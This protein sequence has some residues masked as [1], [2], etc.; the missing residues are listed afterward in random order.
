MLTDLQ[1]HDV[2]SKDYANSF[3]LFAFVW[4]APGSAALPD[5]QNL[6]DRLSMAEELGGQ[7][8]RD[9]NSILE[10]LRNISKDANSTSNTTTTTITG[11]VNSEC[12]HSHF[13]FSTFQMGEISLYST[14]LILLAPFW[15]SLLNTHT[16][17]HTGKLLD[18]AVVYK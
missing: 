3:N 10:Q 14:S 5:M 18:I 11:T 13:F 1:D 9:L 8:S 16:H 7:V 4:M 12:T 15:L 17:T 2:L 6:Y